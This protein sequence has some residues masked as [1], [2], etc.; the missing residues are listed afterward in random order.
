QLVERTADVGSCRTGLRRRGLE[1]EQLGDLLVQCTRLRVWHPDQLA[2]GER[3]DRVRVRAHQ[4][5]RWPGPFHGV[6]VLLGYLLDSW[7]ELAHPPHG[8]LAGEQLTVA[9]VRRG[10]QEDELARTGRLAF[11]LP[12][13]VDG[14]LLQ[15]LA[16]TEARVREDGL[17]LGVPG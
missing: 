12:G 4:V 14:K 10:I 15:L 2:D 16:S 9:A 7:G 6:Q 5:D 8:E 11:H 17:R 3:R 1:R 13:P